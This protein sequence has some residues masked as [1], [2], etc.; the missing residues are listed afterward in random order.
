MERSDVVKHHV[1][2]AVEDG[3]K[4]G[5]GRY[6]SCVSTARNRNGWLRES[7]EG[8]GTVS[9]V[10]L[11]AVAAAMLGAVALAGNLLLCLHHAQNIADM[12]ATAA[13]TAL[14][15]GSSAP[16]AVAERTV[17]GNDAALASCEVD[18]EDVQVVVRVGTQVPL[19][20]HV[21]KQSRAGPIACG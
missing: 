19:M 4:R 7:D 18:G 21:S 14:Y 8:S 9:G 11:I 10:A 5:S 15:K 1:K 2:H 12:S 13:A 20:P 3:V 6:A 17:T 16:C